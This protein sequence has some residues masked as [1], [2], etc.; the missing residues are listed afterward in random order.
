MIFGRVAMAK[1]ALG[2]E[3]FW[4][5][6]YFIKIIGQFGNEKTIAAYVE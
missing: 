3:E 4:T 1:E 2:G 6:G 5:K